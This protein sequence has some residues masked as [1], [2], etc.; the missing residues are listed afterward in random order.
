MVYYIKGMFFIPSV[1][2][3]FHDICLAL[4]HETATVF[5]VKNNWNVGE[6]WYEI[7]ENDGIRLLA[8]HHLGN[9]HSMQIEVD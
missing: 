6:K 3:S 4:N 2:F 5:F 1:H 7:S 8:C 9:K